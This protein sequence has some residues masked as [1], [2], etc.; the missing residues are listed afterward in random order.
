MSDGLPEL[1][2]ELEGWALYLCSLETLN[3]AQGMLDTAIA[4]V[5][6]RLQTRVPGDGLPALEP[7]AAVRKLFRRVGTD[8]TRYRPASEGLARRVLRK[9][10]FPHIAPMVE[11]TN[12]L[13]LELLVP[14][15][16]IKP[17]ALEP[18]LVFRAGEAGEHMD[19][20]R[21]PL[22]LEAKPCLADAA[23]PFASPITDGRRAGVSDADSE[24]LLVVYVPATL[25]RELHVEAAVARLAS[26]TSAARLLETTWVSCP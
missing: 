6:E 20:L 3:P 18:P 25:R 26:A 24:A 11:L 8:P 7:V 17:S 23:G 13:E 21:G 14:A 5:L 19:S 9:G 16:A 15:S 2:C 1:R 12:L 22:D 4:E 10:D